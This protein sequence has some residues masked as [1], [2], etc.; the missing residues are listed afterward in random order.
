MVLVIRVLYQ[1]Q[2][3]LHQN[4][5]EFEREIWI[6]ISKK[7]SFKSPVLFLKTL[8]YLKLLFGPDKLNV[9]IITSNDKLEV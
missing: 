5:V 6:R 1:G 2:I 8:L 9:M 4:T 3:S 7:S